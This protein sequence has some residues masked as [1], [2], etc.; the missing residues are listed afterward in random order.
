MLLKTSRDLQMSFAAVT[1]RVE[2]LSLDT[3]LTKKVEKSL[4]CLVGTRRLTVSIIEQEALLFSKTLIRTKAQEFVAMNKA[5]KN[6]NNSTLIH[7]YQKIWA[8]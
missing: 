1:H 6:V 2:G 8:E 4:V 3:L 7:N 5:F